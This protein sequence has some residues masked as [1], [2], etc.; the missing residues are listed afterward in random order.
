MSPSPHSPASSSP[1]P[2]ILIPIF[3]SPPPAPISPSPHSLLHPPIP[4]LIFLS[5]TPF[6][7]LPSHF[8]LPISCPLPHPHITF[9]IPKFPSIP[10][11]SLPCASV[12][13]STI[14][15]CNP[16]K[17]LILIEALSS[18]H[19]ELLIYPHLPIPMLPSPCSPPPPPCSPSPCSSPPPPCSPSPCSSP[20]P[21]CSPSPPSCS[22]SP[23]S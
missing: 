12:P 15:F 11:I 14:P 4:I 2:L 5:P 18:H 9:L 16:L 1:H 7:Y 8:P 3:I 19:R 6:P 23:C 13:L 20:P 21:P 10:Q 17:F 22:P